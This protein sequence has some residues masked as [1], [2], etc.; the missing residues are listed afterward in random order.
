MGSFRPAHEALSDY[1]GGTQ[2]ISSKNALTWKGK[3]SLPS[4]AQSFKCVANATVVKSNHKRFSA[5]ITEGKTLSSAEHSPR[6]P[7]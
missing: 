1:Y 6:T 2:S 3:V 5:A 4:L 7:H